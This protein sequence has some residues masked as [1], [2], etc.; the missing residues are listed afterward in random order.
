[1]VLTSTKSSRA[2][3]P[4]A[5]RA[6]PNAIYTCTKPASLGPSSVRTNPEVSSMNRSR[7]RCA[8]FALMLGACACATGCGTRPV[9]VEAPTQRPSSPSA[10]AAPQVSLKELLARPRAELAKQFEEVA[11]QVQ[12][13]EKAHRDGTLAF[14]LLTRLRLPLVLPV[15]TEARYSAKLQISLPPYVAEDSKDNHLA[16]H[17]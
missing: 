11:A 4:A 1:H 6:G 16:R 2:V 12:T 9:A 13:R 10:V 7:S 15:W 8:A 3:K 17:L 14:G 5:R